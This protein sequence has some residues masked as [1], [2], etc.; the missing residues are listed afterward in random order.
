MKGPMIQV[1]KNVKLLPPRSNEMLMSLKTNKFG[2][3]TCAKYTTAT[4]R[5]AFDSVRA[6]P[7]QIKIIPP[8]ETTKRPAPAPLEKEEKRPRTTVA[9][10]EKRI[11][12]LTQTIM[13]LQEK[14]NILT[15][16]LETMHRRMELEHL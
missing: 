8:K 6:A 15:K 12:L 9:A 3:V 11:D 16:T 10:L 1:S 7:G 4:P 2:E 5:V 14:T 13:T